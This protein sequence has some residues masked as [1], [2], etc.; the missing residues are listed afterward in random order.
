[1][2]GSLG[3]SPLPNSCL[4]SARM[5]FNDLI[6]KNPKDWD[7]VD[8][9]AEFEQSWRAM[10]EVHQYIQPALAIWVSC[11][12]EDALENALVEK[13]RPLSKKFKERLFENYGPLGSFAS[14]ID[15]AYALSIIEY[16][17]YDDLKIIK[18]I[19]NKFA[20]PKGRFLHFKDKPLAMIFKKFKGYNKGEENALIFLSRS[21][22]CLEALNVNPEVLKAIMGFS[23]L[24]SSPAWSLLL[25]KE[26]I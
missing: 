23:I 19:K 10:A 12:I 17:I 15:I 25:R 6:K 21:T 9:D 13:M 2:P 1:M 22:F 24:T 8:L 26:S 20:H 14:K 4:G 7:D 18:E 11:I 3:G 16:N 5:T